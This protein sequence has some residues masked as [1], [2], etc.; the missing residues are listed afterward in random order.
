VREVGL[1][2]FQDLVARDEHRLPGVGVRHAG[3]VEGGVRRQAL[4]WPE[5]MNP[6]ELVAVA[7]GLDFECVPSLVVAD[8]YRGAGDY[9]SGRRFRV[10]DL[11]Q[12]EE[13]I[14]LVLDEE[15]GASRGLWL[16]EPVMWPLPDPH[17]RRPGPRWRRLAEVAPEEAERLVAPAE[18]WQRL[19]EAIDRSIR[20]AEQWT[21]YCQ[22]VQY[23]VES[24]PVEL[25]PLTVVGKE[26]ADVFGTQLGTHR[27]F[28]PN[29]ERRP[30]PLLIAAGWYWMETEYPQNLPRVLP[31]MREVAVKYAVAAAA[32]RDAILKPVSDRL[33]ASRSRLSACQAQRARFGDRPPT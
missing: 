5:G 27:G 9:T 13:S 3:L 16:E 15:E 33:A 17:R 20:D 18:L 2:V 21:G 31:Q 29:G 19:V 8:G 6:A 1:R 7:L 11:G 23:D 12:V 22:R 26:L 10:L 24:L 25:G 28:L 32:L 30:G 14:R 4:D